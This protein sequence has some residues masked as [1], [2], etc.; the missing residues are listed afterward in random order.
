MKIGIYDPY[1]DDLG[2]GEKYMMSIA[3]CLA[4]DNDV[5]IFW[6]NRRDLDNLSN[7]F[8]IALSNVSL[9]SNIFSPK[10]NI[11]KRLLETRKYDV[12]IFL[13]DGSI[14]LVLAKKL[15]IHIQQPLKTE[16]N[17]LTKLKVSRVD[18][19]F[20]NS[21]YSKSYIDKQMGVASTVLYPPIKINSKNKIKQDII[22]HVGRFRPKDSATGISDYK[23]QSVMVNTFKEMIKSGLKDWKFILAVSIRKGEEGIFEKFRST[24]IGYPIEFLVNKTNDELWDVYSMAKIYWHATGFGEDLIKHPEYAEHFG[25]STVEAMGAGVVP[26][27][28]NAGGQKEIVENGKN[29]FLWDTFS[30]LT[31]KTISLINNDR[32]MKKMSNEAVIRSRYFSGDRFCKEVMNIIEI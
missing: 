6:N 29:G 2:G 31:A 20:C 24:A 18:R 25:I 14:P 22:L 26:V 30:D 4:K 17:I 16:K 10:T 9:V 23:K 8:A 15:F 32:L 5:S 7:R 13:S 3:K 28:V 19:V 21:Y 12:I 1:L 11:I 27:V